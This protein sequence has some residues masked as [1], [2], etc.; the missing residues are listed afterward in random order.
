M[1]ESLQYYSSD[2]GQAHFFR[3]GKKLF[4]LV[5]DANQDVWINIIAFL[6]DGDHANFWFKLPFK[7]DTPPLEIVK[8]LIADGTIRA[9]GMPR[10]E[11]PRS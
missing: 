6:P 5:P 2:E 11:E 9:L 7:T 8:A 1:S 4:D 3:D 10:T